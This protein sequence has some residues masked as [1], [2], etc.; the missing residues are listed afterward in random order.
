MPQTSIFE[1]AGG[2]DG[3][4]RIAAAWHRLRGAGGEGR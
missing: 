1:A 3:M 2:A 4:T